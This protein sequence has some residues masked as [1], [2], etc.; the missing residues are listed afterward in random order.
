VTLS[1]ARVILD[2][3]GVRV[4]G[5][6]LDASVLARKNGSF[7]AKLA[8]GPARVVRTRALADR[9]KAPLIGPP[10]AA[11][12]AHDEDHVCGMQARLEIQRGALLVHE[13]TMS[14]FADLDGKA[15]T[16]PACKP[17]NEQDV[18][19]VR[20]VA[21]RVRV[22]L[23]GAP[24]PDVRGHVSVRGPLLLVNRFV[25]MP[26]LSGWVAFEGDV[27]YGSGMSLPE[28]RGR[29]RG[30]GVALGPY[31]LAKHLLVDVQLKDK[32]VLIP[33]FEMGFGDGTVVATNTRIRPFDDGAPITTERVDGKDVAFEAMMRDLDVTPNTIVKWGLTK[34][35][36][37]AVRG[38][39]HPLHIDADVVADTRGFEVFNSAYHDPARKHVIGVRAAHVRGKIG[40]RRDSLEFY[41]TR[42]EF[43]NSRMLANLVS[44]GFS[45]VLELRI[46]EGS[47]LDLADVT[48]LIDIPM[49]G[50]AELS[51]AMAG[52][53]SDPLLT[54]DLKVTDLVFGGFPVGNITSGKLR[55]KPLYVE[56]ADVRGH[57]G[58][59]EF[60][61]PSARLDFDAGAQVTADAQVHSDKLSLRDFFAMWKF[62][63]DP[64]WADID[65]A[66]KVRAR[67]R[68]V[69]GGPRDVCKSG[70]LE[71]EGSLDFHKLV[72][73]D[74]TFDGAAAE[75]DFRWSDMAASYLGFALDVPSL[76]LRKG[77]GSLL[78]SLGIERGARVRGHFVGSAL[79][80]AKI[81]ALGAPALGIEGSAS[82][83][84]EVSGSL[85]ELAVNAN[86]RVSQLRV[87]SAT[88]PPSD[89]DVSL[90]PLAARQRP[91]GTT[92]CGLPLPEAFDLAEYHADKSAGTFHIGGS[93][94]GGQVRV[95]DLRI[96]RQRAQH[97]AGSIHFAKLELGAL[98][99]LW[100]PM[101][102]AST[103]PRGQLT[104]KLRV[105]ELRTD[106]PSQAQAEL[107]LNELS[108][109]HGAVSLTLLPDSAPIS[110]AK[111]R[112][113]IP[114][115]SLAIQNVRGARGIF[116]VR[117]N[118]ERL[119]K[120][121]V[122]DASLTLR[123]LDLASFAPL[124]PRADRLQGQVRGSLRVSGPFSRLAYAGG[125][126]LSNG[127]VHLRGF[128]SPI[129]D[130]KLALQVNNDE[131]RIASGSARMGNGTL[132]VS[133]GA[134]LKNFELGAVRAVIKARELSTPVYQG[135]RAVLD[136]DLIANLSPGV[137]SGGART[138]PR[139]TGDV[140]LRSFEYTR[141]ISMTADIAAL[142]QRGKRTEFEAYDPADDKLQFDVTV[143]ANR[144]LKITNNLMEMELTTDP[145]GLL[146]AGTNQ[147]FGLR[148]ALR[149]KPG[150]RIRLRQS[151]FEVR[152]GHVKFDD[153]TR[154]APQV[155][156]TA[157]TEYRR[158][159][160][161][162]AD[163]RSNTGAESRG[164]NAAATAGGRW[165]VTMR[166]HG[167]A[168]K[169]RIDLTSEPALAQDDIFL[170]LTVGLTRAEL[171]QAQSASVGESV[172]LEALGTLTGADRA[173]RE[174]V[175]V[176]DEFRFGSA[177]STR[178]GRTE[179]TVTIGK[180]LAER[181]R[182]NV[183][184]G[185]SEAR[186][187]RSNLEWRLSPR[188]SV[189]GSYDNV[190]DI[191]S[192]SLG[193]LGG[194]VRWRLEFE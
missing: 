23:T 144:S 52:K 165:R 173:V 123:P 51:L 190:N 139:V 102:L 3:D 168:D 17:A 37:T 184:S 25:R 136:A 138:L 26:P 14:G 157:T 129:S 42:A 11:P 55:F 44:I 83:V 150:G 65:G 24:L 54:G 132:T 10:P 133:G 56:F 163:T 73:L 107:T 108:L 189:E 22:A 87:G 91:R 146:L 77:T 118:V 72:V 116:D 114:G 162:F 71:V 159:S 95:D 45:N 39:L 154:I 74:E 15:G 19:Q 149:V 88:L 2:V 156:V 94:F 32:D 33:R 7:D 148:G 185:L 62:D 16:L 92:R 35:K 193:N 66:G 99:E 8:A 112:L 43:G 120:V 164:S 106:D 34:T 176:I 177:Y 179:P 140:T 183:T 158:N 63:A 151:E 68:Y 127:E 121:P 181:I 180:R 85:D 174:A 4:H 58:R 46:G 141:P 38:T 101:L 27:A 93:L 78:G 186:E 169:L 128:P 20:V 135:V 182:A 41:D 105:L 13:L 57:K 119:G 31:R 75:F 18:S 143:R 191:S 142:T 175:P 172:A 76:S 40:V 60:T 171:D 134:P 1:D 90:V 111:R 124:I 86:V 49:S 21:S 109:E 113:Q 125:F 69:L 28:L 153:A 187:I 6:D 81:D 170:L 130:V 155:D 145:Q 147:R 36:V 84:A 70:A 122:L 166:A 178:T 29:L 53:M 97:I 67:V 167:D 103:K 80:L 160:D 194:D 192:S 9:S 96:T 117:G 89:L 188:V 12:P 115:L 126:A 59:S 137:L 152:Q 48:P 104:G 79:P 98:S 50:S 82:T 5:E 131:L 61:V 100:P 47:K 161:S 64:R 30:A 110:V